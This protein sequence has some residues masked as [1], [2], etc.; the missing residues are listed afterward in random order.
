[1]KKIGCFVFSYILLLLFIISPAVAQMD[2]K[3]GQQVG[4]ETKVVEGV[5]GRLKVTPFFT[6]EVK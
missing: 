4:E 2:H 6:Y 3:M 5:K 1:M